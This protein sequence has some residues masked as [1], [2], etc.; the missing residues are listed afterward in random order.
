VNS[1]ANITHTVPRS[2][3]LTFAITGA[4]VLLGL[5]LIAA[6][7]LR[8]FVP[9]RGPSFPAKATALLET[10][11]ASYLMT[12]VYV[13]EFVVGLCLLSG[14]FVPLALLVFAPVH[15]NI[16]LL[17][18]FLDLQ[19][20]RIAQII[21]MLGCHLF[22]VWA[23][24]ARFVPLLTIRSTV[25]L[26]RSLIILRVLLAVLMF[27]PGSAKLALPFASLEYGQPFMTALHDSGFLFT[28]LALSEIVIGFLVLLNLFTPLALV[29]LAPIVLNILAFQVF[30]RPTL[31]GWGATLFLIIAS[32][33]LAWYYREYYRSVL[34]P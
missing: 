32:S 24:W 19:P 16:I 33:L 8:V 13:T 28:L 31:N 20:V 2:H 14:R 30:I 7:L 29:L 21:V 1:A 27:V 10:M 5:I 34:S 11:Q 4:R 15:L 25:N 23:H 17:H 18:L 3:A 12:F 9:E 22:L 26:Q 6:V